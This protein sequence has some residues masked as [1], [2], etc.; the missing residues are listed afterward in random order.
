MTH[1][2]PSRQAEERGPS[3]DRHSTPR[4]SQESIYDKHRMPKAARVRVA[5]GKANR[6]R[7]DEDCLLTLDR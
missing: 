5:S 7:V 4:S 2:K 3:A 1:S 6:L